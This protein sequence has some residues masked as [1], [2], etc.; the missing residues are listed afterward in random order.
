MLIL[1]SVGFMF[2]GEKGVKGVFG[3]VVFV[4]LVDVWLMMW[5]LVLIG[6]IMFEEV[7]VREVLDWELVSVG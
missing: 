3:L 1:G 4:V 6:V 5:E 2:V 7:E